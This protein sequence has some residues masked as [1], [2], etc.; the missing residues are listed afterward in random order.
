MYGGFNPWEMRLKQ[1]L[2][3]NIG[4]VPHPSLMGGTRL[5][6]SKWGLDWGGQGLGPGGMGLD[7]SRAKMGADGSRS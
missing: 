3:M 5:V 4:G 6:E 2:E 1:T 7:R